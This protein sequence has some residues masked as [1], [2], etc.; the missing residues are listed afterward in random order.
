MLKTIFFC[1]SAAISLQVTIALSCYSEEPQVFEI[2]KFEDIVFRLHVMPSASLDREECLRIEAKNT[3]SERWS[4]KSDGYVWPVE[5]RVLGETSDSPI[6][7]L[8]PN[9]QTLGLHFSLSWIESNFSR[10]HHLISSNSLSNTLFSDA[11]FEVRSIELKLRTKLRMPIREQSLAT[12]ET[13]VRFEMG[14][15]SKQAIQRL[16]EWLREFSR[17]N[18]TSEIDIER[19]R[20]ICA[21]PY[22][23]R[24]LGIS[25][26][27]DLLDVLMKFPRLGSLRPQ[28]V[29]SIS[30]YGI[31][32]EITGF[33]MTELMEGNVAAVSDI[34]E[35]NLLWH[36]ELLEPLQKLFLSNQNSSVRRDILRALRKHDRLNI[37][38]TQP[39]VAELHRTGEMERWNEWSKELIEVIE[40]LNDPTLVKF[41]VLQLD[42]QKHVPSGLGLS[43]GVGPQI[44]PIRI[45]DYAHDAIVMI[46]SVN[47]DADAS[48]NGRIA[49]AYDKCQLTNEFDPRALRFKL[50][51]QG[52]PVNLAY[53]VEEKVEDLSARD[54]QLYAQVRTVRDTMI[55]MLKTDLAKL[56]TP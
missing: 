45:C 30:I 16:V 36:D 5:F 27:L 44:P 10:E 4:K 11:D 51:R 49:M 54:R 8:L 55:E 41:L 22:C 33:Y 35:S 17:S 23:I 37:T 18:A 31:P 13:T 15:P 29:N 12:Q 21:I 26:T 56:A 42:N 1:L 38:T 39:I 47:L 53:P 52:V 46:A 9:M 43:T 32:A 20:S 28:I 3:S 50:P 40:L 7:E 6:Y 19:L 2:A 34:Q 24:S 25:D 48:L 14:L